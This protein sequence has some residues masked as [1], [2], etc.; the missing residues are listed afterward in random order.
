MA[1]AIE[2]RHRIF[3]Q[4]LP[5]TWRVGA[6][7]G[8]YAFVQHPFKDI[9]ST[10]VCEK[11]AKMMGVIC[12]PA[13][14]FE[15]VGIDGGKGGQQWVRFSVANVSDEKIRLVCERLKESEERFGWDLDSS[16]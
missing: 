8:Y 15:P 3:K 2:K 14:F 10:A 4:S 5:A 11:L 7:G 12:L 16:I 13:G 6:Q 9:D 1:G